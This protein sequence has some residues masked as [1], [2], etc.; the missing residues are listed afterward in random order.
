VPRPVT[1]HSGKTRSPSVLH[2]SEDSVIMTVPAAGF[3]STICTP[4]KVVSR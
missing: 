2:V 1:S 3:Y 4:R